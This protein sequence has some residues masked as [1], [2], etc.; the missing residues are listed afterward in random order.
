MGSVRSAT[1]VSGAARRGAAALIVALAV[2]VVLLPVSLSALVWSG[3]VPGVVAVALI[4][5]AFVALHGASLIAVRHP[6]AGSAVASAVMLALVVFPAARET[7]AAMYP[8][9]LAY[10]LCLTQVA[11]QRRVRLSVVALGIGVVGA[12]LIALVEPAFGV[13]TRGLDPLLLR[14]G[15]FLG[16][17]AAVVAAWACGLL[18]RSATARAEERARMRVEQAI[19]E[20]RVRI[21]GELHDVVAH[22]MTVMIA[23]SEV[24][25]AVVRE[26]P[27]VSE[28]ALGVVV[29]TGREAL[30]G[31]RAIVRAEGSAPT[32]PVPTADA[33]PA[34]VEAV[35]S[36]ACAAVFTETGERRPLPA[37]VMLALHR[38]IRE[39]LTNAVRHTAPP[40]RIEVAVTWTAERVI[41][42]VT[43]DGGSG[44]GE[45]GLG[46]GTG[47]IGLAER[48]RL[49]DGV[50]R[51]GP[52]GSDGWTVRAELPGR[53]EGA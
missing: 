10:L 36:P 34:L 38:T 17:T 51:A 33:L 18:I 43:D 52:D 8:S 7:S 4:A 50:F 9:S 37:A 26:D 21:S 14:G 53:E 12:A 42:E 45:T 28:R 44:P 19:V 48:I 13:P 15:A 46:T 16:L 1:G 35:R 25:R 47:L 2:L 20:E 32:E 39:G 29:A 31:M 30:R 3:P 11:A 5:L 6:V 40:V 41:A 27:A 24:A 49:V 23:Q 22:A